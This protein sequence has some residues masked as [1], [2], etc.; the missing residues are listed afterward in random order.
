MVRNSLCHRRFEEWAWLFTEV[1]VM[2]NSA[3][4]LLPKE[5]PFTVDLA[6]RVRLGLF[7]WQCYDFIHQHAALLVD[8]K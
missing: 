4:L 3:V 2:Q 1:R 6:A 7:W 8:R 5:A